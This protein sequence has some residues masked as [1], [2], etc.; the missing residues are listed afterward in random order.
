MRTG[1]M[2][3]TCSDFVYLILHS[4]KL[5]AI[6]VITVILH[7]YDTQLHSSH[8][9]HYRPQNHGSSNAVNF[10]RAQDAAEVR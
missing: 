4:Y 2:K 6:W 10:Y 9:S 7:L 3:R 1:E 5:Q 8:N